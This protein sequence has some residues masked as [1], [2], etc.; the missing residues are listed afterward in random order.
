MTAR[1]ARIF[2]LLLPVLLL[3]LITWGQQQAP[4]PE[5][6]QALR[7]RV[8]E[9]LQYHVDGNFRKAYDMVA[10]DTKDHYFNA[11]K[12]QL[13]GFK[14]DDIKFTDNFTKA[15]VVATMSKTVNVAGT[16]LPVSLPSTITWKIENGKW[17]WYAEVNPAAAWSTP[18]GLGAPPPGA[19]A[20]A[21]SNDTAGSPLPKN[22]N[23]QTIA[24]VGRS[25]LQQVSVDKKA[26]TLAAD[27]A[28]E[29]TVVLHNGMPGSVQVELTAP[30]IPGFS[31]KLSQAI[32]RAAGD[33]QVVFRYE[34]GDRTARLDPISVLLTVQPLNQPFPI[35][36]N[37]AG[38]K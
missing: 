1:I 8:T 17:V 10:E 25:I 9:F 23:D 12:A 19:A 34:P 5:V 28:S 33:V 36:V 26:I 4:P 27:K 22:L 21:K 14:I 31:V 30:E 37:F 6:E 13:L 38:S 29:E 24:A 20:P 7:A 18:L 35:Q 2:P 11:G 16:V 3:P 32:V 15:S